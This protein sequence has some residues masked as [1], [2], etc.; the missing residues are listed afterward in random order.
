M[1]ITDLS[2]DSFVD[3]KPVSYQFG[4]VHGDSFDDNWLVIRGAVAS[5][6]ESWSFRDPCLLVNEARSM[7][8]WLRDAAQGCIP[9]VSPED[10]GEP[11]PSFSAI[12]PNLGLD[13]VAFD[14]RSI[15]VRFHLGLESGPPSIRE[16]D[17][18]D[19]FLDLTTTPQALWKASEEW[20]LELDRFP[21]R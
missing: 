12:E 7:G 4:H 15:T 1:R 14:P 2:G 13:I 6:V 8:I 11:N 16:H 19:Y 9:L 10:S 21:R 5:A 18:E 17:P 20:D 3:L